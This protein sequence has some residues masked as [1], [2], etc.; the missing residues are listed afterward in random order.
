MHG[1]LKPWVLA[2]GL[3]LFAELSPAAGFGRINVT[4][5]LGQP[6][7]AEIDLL[8]VSNED[9]QAMTVKL[10]SQ[11]AFREA[12]VEYSSALASVRFSIEKRASGQ[13]FIRVTSTSPISEPAIN[14]LVEVNWPAGR[15]LRDY[16]VLLNPTGYL[17]DKALADAAKATPPVPPEVAVKPASVPPAASPAPAPAQAQA[18]GAAA[19]P[20]AKAPPRARAAGGGSRNTAA[21]GK[22]GEA[23]TV[24]P[25]DTL[26]ALAVANRPA[27]V[28]IEQTMLA[29]FEANRSAFISD[30]IHRIRAGK[31]IHL[32]T[33]D[34]AAAVQ[35]EE[36]SRRI[37]LLSSDFE[38]YR[39]RLAD[40]AAG[41]PSQAPQAKGPVSGKLSASAE[42]ATPPKPGGSDVL[43]ISKS[44]A[45]GDD[46]GLAKRRGAAD[47][48]AARQEDETVAKENQ[49]RE[50]RERVAA[51]E[52]NVAQMR[53]LLNEK[54]DPA[55]AEA[56]K[57]AT[58]KADAAKADVAKAE[59]AKAEAAKQK[60]AAAQ[61]EAA[62]AEAAKADA[63]KAE[64][65]K[66]EAAK[67]EVA[68]AEAAKAE[69]AK[70]TK[71]PAVEAA[72][73][74]KP[75]AAVPAVVPEALKPATPADAD[76]NPANKPVDKP[77][78]QAKPEPS[79]VDDV[80]GALSDNPLIGV[81]GAL[82]AGLVS[83][84]G[85]GALRRRRDHTESLF[86]PTVNAGDP[87]TV[88]AVTSDK[89]SALVDTTGAFE[90][91]FDRT[92]PEQHVDEV[93]PVAEADVYIAYGRDVQAEEILREAMAK[94]PERT[95]IL[96]KLLEIYAQRNSRDE[97]ASHARQLLERVGPDHPLWSA[98]MAMGHE[99]DP[100]NPLY[101]AAGMAFTPPPPAVASGREPVDLD[102]GMAD[103]ADDAAI[104]ASIAAIGLPDL[105]P[106]AYTPEAL[107]PE[108][109]TPGSGTPEQR[110]GA[111]L[112]SHEIDLGDEPLQP[113]IS[114]FHSAGS[115]VPAVHPETGVVAEIQGHE[116]ENVSHPAVV[117]D[118][119]THP[120][121][122]APPAAGLGLDEAHAAPALMPAA[123]APAAAAPTAAPTAAPAPAPA[124]AAGTWPSLTGH[125]AE[126]VAASNV[127]TPPPQGDPFTLDFDLGLGA[128]PAAAAAAGS[129]SH[130]VLNHGAGIH[131]AGGL[132]LGVIDLD[133]IKDS[134]PDLPVPGAPSGPAVPPAL[135]PSVLEG[136]GPTH[137]TPRG[138]GDIDLDLGPEPAAMA[139]HEPAAVHDAPAQR[140]SEWH[141][142]AT[143]LDLARAYLEIG[144]REGAGEIL[145]E[146]LQE[147][148]A[149]QR[150]EASRLV[151]GI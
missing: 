104:A 68:K 87:M 11:E 88:D 27:S 118:S 20:A 112:A 39:K 5:A 17:A 140:S 116:Y 65:A 98:A 14:L 83:W 21:S 25:G 105:E 136:T 77:V 89:A 3:A 148:D 133:L 16:P 96:M 151:S 36:A 114:E 50:A 113:G 49:L 99:I 101:Q 90:T 73:G 84:L 8:N 85:L 76:K 55:K 32:P 149:E 56:L 48:R 100:G 18:A 33:S 62:K 128:K 10:A 74:D 24:K 129:A 146:V 97:Y 44:A 80:L 95:E 125:D 135:P 117:H 4:S 40:A 59:A 139:A 141:N 54:A 145:R 64:A 61:A 15:L 31:Q 106:M 19:S 143:K 126:L 6:L 119:L 12:N 37:S 110:A 69:A 71:P 124:P 52:G 111:R 42:D 78:T 79:M 150:A 34:E 47:E 13:A 60:T 30:S 66:A 127:A 63:A 45:R 121:A 115:D 75:V 43:Q 94:D 58:A 9:V 132:D 131:G 28:S 130:G 142:V 122:V 51:L 41:K 29:M 134:S 35:A 82:A 7:A 46:K 86:A 120:A 91:G 22:P 67:A 108:V 103:H 81:A 144:D 137:P 26:R 123:G 38:A 93:D 1:K 70:A 72:G 107:S 109:F 92:V 138:F 2:I 102:L 147:G 23:Y 53:K 57:A